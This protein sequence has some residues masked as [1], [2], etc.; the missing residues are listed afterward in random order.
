ME[1]AR[2]KQS[3]GNSSKHV[4]GVG[5]GQGIM[6][7]SIVNFNK[8]QMSASANNKMHMQT[9]SEKVTTQINSKSASSKSANATS[10]TV[11]TG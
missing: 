1:Q 7:N 10:S 6:D 8:N 4:G 9:L 11:P 2:K 3:L 5:D